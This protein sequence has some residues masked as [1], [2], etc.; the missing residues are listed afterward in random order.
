MAGGDQNGGGSPGPG[1]QPDPPPPPITEP[2]PAGGDQ[3]GTGDPPPPPSAD[4][5]PATDW[6]DRRI[7]EQQQRLRERNARI[8]QLEAEL[9]VARGGQPPTQPPPGNGQGYQQQQPNQPT[10]TGPP[11]DIQRQ[12]N[13]AAA[14]LAAGQEFTRRCNEVAEAGRKVYNNFD[15][16]VQRLVGLVDGNDQQQVQAYNNFL[17]AA[18]ETGQATRL[19]YDLGGDLNEASRI[20]AME[21]V[22][23]AVELTRLSARVT[24]TDQ[25]GAPRPLTPI[26]SGVQGQRASIQPDDPDSADNLST[27]DWMAR[28]EEQV[29]SRRQRTLG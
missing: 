24:T 4:A 22:K 5:P 10:F 27:E 1:G 6:R 18:M 9:N 12:I 11:G 26:S 29:A 17:S 19:I 20:M 7:G 23:M 28:R 3:G 16:R 15:Q 13:E 25:T 14:A 8:A 21:P 2:P